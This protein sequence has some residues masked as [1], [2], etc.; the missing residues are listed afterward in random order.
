[1]T[2]IYTIKINTVTEKIQITFS[3]TLQERLS[4]RKF[5]RRNLQW[6]IQQ[7]VW[8]EFNASSKRYSVTPYK[9]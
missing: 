4:V 2:L 5:H 9:S 6:G 8:G 7:Y 3:C 1:M